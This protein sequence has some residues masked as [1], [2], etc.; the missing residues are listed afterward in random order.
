M[1]S[2]V[3]LELFLTLQKDGGVK[4]PIGM[5]RDVRTRWGSSIRMLQR[6][7]RTREFIKQWLQDPRN[8]SLQ[9]LYPTADEW[10]QIEYV[11]TILHPFH[12]YTYLLS[13]SQEPT[14]QHTWQIYNDLFD[15]L[16]KTK[17]LLRHKRKLW[18]KNILHAIEPARLKLDEYYSKTYAPRG[19]IYNI[20]N[21]LNPSNKLS[22]YD[23]P[24]WAMAIEDPADL[25]T[26]SENIPSFKEQY[27][28]EFLD[29]YNKYYHHL[30]ANYDSSN[31]SENE[32]PRASNLT[33]TEEL[34][35]SLSGRLFTRQNKT[36]ETGRWN[37]AIDYLSTP[38]EPTGTDILG[39]WRKY[40]SKYHALSIMARDFLAIP[41]AG[42][43]VE[44]VFSAC[45]DVVTYRRSRLLGKT[46][47]DIMICKSIWKNE[48][49]E[50]NE[51]LIDS[52]DKDKL[53]E[54]LL[55]NGEPQ[56][57]D[58]VELK[59][60]WR[61]WDDRDRGSISDDE[62]DEDENYNSADENRG[63]RRR[64]NKRQANETEQM[65]SRTNKRM[66]TTMSRPG[67]SIYVSRTNA[68]LSTLSTAQLRSRH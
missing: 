17:E 63:P 2:T 60:D 4:N 41:V 28:K 67:Q 10:K 37:E 6:A 25:Q 18:K 68:A 14:I 38:R 40:E 64:S 55:N 46:I 52:E 27:R 51:G 1:C 56:Q 42:V 58:L 34:S 19:K 65:S 11:I 9:Y 39:Y 62:D 24:E 30:Q 8:R 12:K 48:E 31:Q 49:I 29:H 20:G 32:A 13:Y 57:E 45:R 59:V 21:I 50:N 47:D 66:Q 33:A 54:K 23:R 61:R 16:E 15:H 22:T 7:C 5:V 26:S 44:R 36:T 43:G 3:R 35:F 53:V